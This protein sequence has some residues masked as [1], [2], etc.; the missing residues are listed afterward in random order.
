MK[1]IAVSVVFHN[2]LVNICSASTGAISGRC[3][4]LL[5]PP[6]LAL[7]SRLSPAPWD[8]RPPSHSAALLPSCPSLGSLAFHLS[9]LARPH[10]RIPH[11]TPFTTC[12]QKVQQLM[13]P[14]IDAHHSP[15]L[16]Q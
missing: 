4:I 15:Q 8:G 14:R 1:T 9:L 6:V 16:T 7:A 3:W 12:T 11:N 10:S 13:E 5:G 2:H